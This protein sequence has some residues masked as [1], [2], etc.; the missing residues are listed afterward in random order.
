MTLRSGHGTGRGVPR[1]EV[2]PVDELPVGVAVLKPPR[3]AMPRPPYAA[4]SPEASEAGRRGGH[5]RAG[6]TRLAAQLTLATDLADPSV[7]PYLRAAVPFQKA[8][9]ESI[10]ATVGGGICDA[11]ASSMVATAALQLATSRHAFEVEGD[12]IK[13]SRLADASRQNLLAAT[14]IAARTAAARARVSPADL[15]RQLAEAFGPPATEL[16]R[17]SRQ[18]T[19]GGVAVTVTTSGATDDASPPAG[20]QGAPCG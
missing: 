8:A 14:E 20:D 5:A 15:H 12:A 4:G 16:P 11:L 2:L 17:L 18:E 7:R 9:L 3:Q 19:P 1:V 10:A 6:K 13:G